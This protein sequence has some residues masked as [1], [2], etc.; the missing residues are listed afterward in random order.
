MVA[1]G[2]LWLEVMRCR[3]LAVVPLLAVVACAGDDHA[4]ARFGNATEGQLRRAVEAAMWVDVDFAIQV[5]AQAW[6][7]NQPGCPRVSSVG[8]V[9]AVHTDCTTATGWTLTGELVV[10]NFGVAAGPLLDPAQDSQLVAH[11]LRVTDG[12]RVATLDGTVTIAAG[13]APDGPRAFTAVL[14]RSTDGLAA[15]TDGTLTCDGD[16][17]CQVDDGWIAVETLGEARVDAAPFVEGTGHVLV[18]GADTMRIDLEA[19]SSGCRMA[20]VG[21]TWNNVCPPLQPPAWPW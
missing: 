2:V 8:L 9:T 18:R 13:Y 6:G 4:S 17:L 3:A 5:G 11:A 19:N 10:T 21:D 15:H 1:R 14:D 12:T 7:R 20:T 16:G